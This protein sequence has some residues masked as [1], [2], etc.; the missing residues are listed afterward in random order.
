MKHRFVFGKHWERL[1]FDVFRRNAALLLRYHGQECPEGVDWKNLYHRM[2][3]CD[4][5]H[6][7]M[8][9]EQMVREL[10]P[11]PRPERLKARVYEGTRFYGGEP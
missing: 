9:D 6:Y 11:D 3:V 7:L 2:C 5:V 4:A 8:G 10:L 1:S